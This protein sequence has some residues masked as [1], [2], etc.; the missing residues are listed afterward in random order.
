MRR[1]KR[2]AFWARQSTCCNGQI[3]LH[4]GPQPSHNPLNIAEVQS[5]GALEGNGNH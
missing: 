5:K 4:G 1:K 2:S 3:A